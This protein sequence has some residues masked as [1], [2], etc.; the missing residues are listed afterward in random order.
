MIKFLL[1]VKA[2]LQVVVLPTAVIYAAW[3]LDLPGVRS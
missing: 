2:I 1:T 3:L